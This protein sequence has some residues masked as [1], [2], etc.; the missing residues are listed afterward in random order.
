MMVLWLLALLLTMAQHVGKTIS[1]DV[2]IAL[3]LGFIVGFALARALAVL[4]QRFAPKSP[5]SYPPT[6]DAPKSKPGE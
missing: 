5:P 4:P 1:P 6:L 3:C 2:V